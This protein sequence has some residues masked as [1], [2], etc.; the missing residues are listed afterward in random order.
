MKS[1]T[2]FYQLEFE[3]P[4]PERPPLELEELLELELE[5]LL[6]LELEEL[7]ELELEELHD[8]RDCLALSFL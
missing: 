5:E 1:N 2:L 3:P 6:E 8:E 7:L 4:P